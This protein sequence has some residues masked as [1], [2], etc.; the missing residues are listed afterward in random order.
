MSNLG[1]SDAMAQSGSVG[2]VNATLAPTDHTAASY[3]A[4]R[5]KI[6]RF[7]V[8]QGLD[9]DNAQELTQEVFVQLF[10]A[11]KGGRKIE[12]EQAWLYRVASNLAVNYWRRE[13]GPMWVELDSAQDVV[14]NSS[15]LDS[16][17]EM[18]AVEGQKLRRV[19]AAMANLPK[20]QRLSIH[21][22]MQ[23]LRY[24]EIAKVLGVSITTV[25]TLLSVAVERLRS[26]ANE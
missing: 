19:A 5:V 12:S 24:K 10:V 21:L 16:T 13:G 15:S 3:E 11:L 8:G 23:G 20:E 2:V 25:N 26:T 22:R 18:A 9:P 14:E 17:P 4:H 6:Y 1:I 7:L